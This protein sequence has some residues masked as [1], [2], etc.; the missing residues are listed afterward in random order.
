M[1]LF[2]KFFGT[3]SEREVKRILPLV[4]RIEALEAEYT[5]LSDEALRAKTA[6]FKQ[7]YEAG[8]TL[9]DLLVEAF[10]AVR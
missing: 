9:D 1:G 5:A 6:E 3:R 8:E 2:D 10:A 4:D 7:R